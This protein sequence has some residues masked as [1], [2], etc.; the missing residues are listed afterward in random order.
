MDGGNFSAAEQAHIQKLMEKRTIEDMMKSYSNMIDKCF[1]TCCNDFTS[2]A[3]ST[4]E[5]QCINFCADK[6]LKYSERV[7]MRFQE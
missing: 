5:E 1:N 6:F 7:S 3:L 2:K 4:K